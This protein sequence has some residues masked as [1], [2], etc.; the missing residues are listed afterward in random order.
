M[1]VPRCLGCSRGITR[2]VSSLCVVRALPSLPEQEITESTAEK[3]EMHQKEAE[4]EAGNAALQLAG[5]PALINA[6][7]FSSLKQTS[8]MQLYLMPVPALHAFCS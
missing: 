8:V 3:Q 6:V 1:L 7:Y 2:A 4:Q 5:A